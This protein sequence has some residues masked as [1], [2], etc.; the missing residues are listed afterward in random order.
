LFLPA[1][2]L[3]YFKVTGIEKTDESVAIHLE[4]QNVPLW[5]YPNQKLTSKGFYEP[6][7]VKDFPIRGKSCF[8]KIKRRRWQ[9]EESAKIVSRDWNLVA[10]GTRMT[11]EF[12]TFLKGI[13]G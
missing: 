4:E 10:Q 6:V 3:D 9:V 13:V 5:E 2:V 11:Q 8:L 12:A 7:T 1:G